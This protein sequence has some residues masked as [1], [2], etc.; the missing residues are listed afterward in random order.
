[1]DRF[2][3]VNI[4]IVLV[5]LIGFTAASLGVL[6]YLVADH[7]HDDPPV[8]LVGL[9]TTLVGLVTGS[10][11]STAAPA[12]VD[13]ALRAATGSTTALTTYYPLEQAP[14]V[15]QAEL[16]DV[17]TPEGVTDALGA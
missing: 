16:D 2:G 12:R 4:R 14:D 5:A 11:I 6:L 7:P 8:L 17:S 1:M 3:A 9:V 15:D 10:Q 13:A